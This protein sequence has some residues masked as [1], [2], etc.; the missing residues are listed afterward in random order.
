MPVPRLFLFLQHGANL[1]A[2]LNDTD[3]LAIAG[4]DQGIDPVIEEFIFA[5]YRLAPD[6]CD[7]IDAK[8]NLPAIRSMQ[9]QQDDRNFDH[10]SPNPEIIHLVDVILMA[11]AMPLA[12]SVRL[13]V[14]PPGERAIVSDVMAMVSVL[15][16]LMNMI[17]VPIG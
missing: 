3:I 6:G 15:I 12:A 11:V 5:V 17:L 7:G 10:V 4:I 9:D 16:S 2:R 14:V 13:P 1:L 8:V